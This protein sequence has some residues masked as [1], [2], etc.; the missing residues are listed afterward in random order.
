[1]R[2]AAG[3]ECRVQSAECGMSAVATGTGPRPRLSSEGSSF[4]RSAMEDGSCFARIVM[5]DSWLTVC[6]WSPAKF[7][8]AD[9]RSVC[10]FIDFFNGWRRRGKA[11]AERVG[12]RLFHI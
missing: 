9:W 10:V 8:V 12:S 5:E 3:D 7:R 11:F 6:G 4:A 2:A 1:M